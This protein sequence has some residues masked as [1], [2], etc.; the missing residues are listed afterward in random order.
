[1]QHGNI[2]TKITLKVTDTDKINIA[3]S[4]VVFEWSSFRMDARSKSSRLVVNSRLF[5]ATPD[6]D[7]PPFIDATDFCLVDTTLHD[8]PDVVIDWVQIWDIWMPQVRRNKV[9]CLLV[10][11]VNGL[12]CMMR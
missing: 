12:T 9:W 11:K 10:Q 8:N 2:H 6:V 1:M 4:Q 3:S 5:K 7:R